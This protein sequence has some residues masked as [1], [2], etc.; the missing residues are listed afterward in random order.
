MSDQPKPL[1]AG[2]RAESIIAYLGSVYEKQGNHAHP[3]DSVSE[4][5][6]QQIRDAERQA[7][8][9]GREQLVGRLLTFD[10]KQGF[11]GHLST[12]SGARTGRDAG[13]GPPSSG[14]LDKLLEEEE[15]ETYEAVCIELGISDG[16]KDVNPPDGDYLRLIREHKE[17][18]L[19]EAKAGA[20]R[21][22][23][24]H[25]LPK[26]DKG[27]LQPEEALDWC[28]KRIAELSREKK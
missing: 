4:A 5:V 8:E 25:L 14:A 13:G 9:R 21:S 26:H 10:G 16:A 3:G 6:E 1:S 15:R 24:Q 12:H 23:R 20:F 7:E 22:V 11:S 19:R 27:V 18:L 17:K 2:V 28:D